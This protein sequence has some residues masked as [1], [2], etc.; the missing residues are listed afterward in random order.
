MILAQASHGRVPI[1]PTLVKKTGRESGRERNKPA[2]DPPELPDDQTTSDPTPAGGSV[3]LKASPP[4]TTP[5][6]TVPARNLPVP[7]PP[8]AVAAAPKTNGANQPGPSVKKSEPAAVAPPTVTSRPTAATVPA[9]PPSAP[10]APVYKEATVLE[11]FVG[12]KYP[13]EARENDIEGTVR[14]Q[15]AVSADG[16]VTDVRVLQG[17]G[18]GLDEEAVRRVRRYSFTPATRNGVPIDTTTPVSIRFELK[19]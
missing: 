19:D 9:L 4:S 5:I 15:V 8:V 13:D 11:R 16:K 10:A 14:L 2:V 1:K 6:S 18:Y 7:L 12:G 17:L 3:P